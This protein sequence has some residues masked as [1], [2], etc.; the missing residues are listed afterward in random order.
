MY[1]A[2]EKTDTSYVMPYE[3]ILDVREFNTADY[4]CNNY[5]DWSDFLITSNHYLEFT[6]S[7]R[8]GE[9]WCLSIQSKVNE[10]RSSTHVY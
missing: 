4:Y 10:N 7:L 8:E 5:T 6:Y 9:P 3:F 2:E 1:S